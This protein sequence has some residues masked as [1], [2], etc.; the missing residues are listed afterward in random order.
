MIE[1]KIP[2]ELGVVDR[3][4]G[5]LGDTAE[6]RDIAEESGAAEGLG[7]A[8]EQWVAG[9]S[10]RS[11]TIPPLFGEHRTWWTSQPSSS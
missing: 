3:T 7:T 8:E 6:E 2:C 5:T 1:E 11:S 4:F 9:R 10:W